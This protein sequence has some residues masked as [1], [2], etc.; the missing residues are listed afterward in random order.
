MKRVILIFVIFIITACNQD[1]IEKTKEL[2]IN[3]SNL[4]IKKH[5]TQVNQKEYNPIKPNSIKE[6]SQKR[7]LQNNNQNKL[8]LEKLKEQN[9]KDLIILKN[10]NEQKL[11]ELDLT[12]KKE[13]ANIEL[14]KKISDNNRSITISQIENS[15]KAQVLEKQNE[16]L[17][18]VIILIAIVIIIW[19]ILR[20]LNQLSK[21]KLE[22][23]TKEKELN[24]QI[25]LEEL[26]IKHQSL[27]KMLDI[28]NDENCDKDIKKSLTKVL[29][30]G[31]NLL[32]K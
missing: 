19:L 11:K 24:N 9:K 12:N 13:L 25:Y 2:N 8:E 10:Q 6:E 27:N 20:Y 4:N 5:I 31:K 16:T 3:N 28:I 22:E 17:K 15:T 14:Q 21:N 26:K 30:N 1:S 23:A 18:I 7:V 32:D 29:E